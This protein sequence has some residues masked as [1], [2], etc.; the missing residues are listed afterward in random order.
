ML[1]INKFS[2]TS[3]ETQLRLPAP[4][5]Q[6]PQLFGPPHHQAPQLLAPPHQLGL[7]N[8]SLLPGQAAEVSQEQLQHLS[9]GNLGGNHEAKKAT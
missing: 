3:L 7:T 6:A 2:E 4:H 9:P 1:R 5:H 8:L